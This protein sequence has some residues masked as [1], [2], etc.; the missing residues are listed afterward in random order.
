MY[1]K[2]PKD[3]FFQALDGQLTGQSLLTVSLS[4]IQTYP[5]KKF[6]QRN[7]YYLESANKI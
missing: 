6:F 5:Q 3:F 2:M 1:S 4:K 7:K